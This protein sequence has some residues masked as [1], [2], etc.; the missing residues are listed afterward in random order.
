MQAT[1]QIPSRQSVSSVCGKADRR[2]HL[3]ECVSCLSPP[4]LLL[5]KPALTADL[6]SS[7][8]LE[9]KIDGD[10]ECEVQF[11]SVKLQ[12]EPAAVPETESPN[13]P[14]C[15][16]VEA[17]CD[18]SSPDSTPTSNCGTCVPPCQQ[19]QCLFTQ[20]PLGAVDQPPYRRILSPIITNGSL[21][22]ETT[23]V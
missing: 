2:S 9:S 23:P 19:T 10:S 20:L 11:P 13:S 18:I 12:P 5:H 3:C 4:L 14:E 16:N 6:F 22:G 15:S 21:S 1:V 17:R 8:D 7:L